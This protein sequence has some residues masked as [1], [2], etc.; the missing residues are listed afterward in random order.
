MIFLVKTKIKS[1]TKLS[2]GRG[3]AFLKFKE[4]FVT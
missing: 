2:D 4:T 1:L 3:F